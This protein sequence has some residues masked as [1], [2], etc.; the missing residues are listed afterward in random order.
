MKP[1]EEQFNQLYHQYADSIRK[2]CLGYTGDAMR[3]DDLLQ[4][5]FVKVWNNMHKFRGEA[6]WGTWIYRIAVNTCL[7]MLRNKKETWMDMDEKKLHAIP[8]HSDTKE[9]QVQLLY[10][11][12]SRLAETDRLLITLVLEDKPYSEIAAI[13]GFTETNIRVKI[14]RIKKQLSDIFNSYEMPT[15]SRTT[16]HK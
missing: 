1:K 15:N 6:A 3:A 4:E 11:C 2:L 9:H 5:T 16:E 14:H 7:S 12:I 13:T 8:D 10:R